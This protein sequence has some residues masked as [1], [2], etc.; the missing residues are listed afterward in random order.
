MAEWTQIRIKKSVL[1][2]LNKMAK[3][4]GRS[5]ANYLEQLILKDAES[6]Q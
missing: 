4:D 5:Q 3:E 2:I 6:K 1:A